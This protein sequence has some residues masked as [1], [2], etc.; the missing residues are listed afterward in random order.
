MVPV[1]IKIL[2]QVVDG[3]LPKGYSY[4]GTPA[5]WIQIRCLQ[6]M[7][8]LGHDDLRYKLKPL[9]TELRSLRKERQITIFHISVLNEKKTMNRK[10]NNL[11][12]E[13]EIE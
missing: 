12:D 3:K 4:H 7:A 5:P 10:D 13:G 6:I 9:K 2:Q 8:K 11:V 1:L